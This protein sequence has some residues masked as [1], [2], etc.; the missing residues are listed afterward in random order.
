MLACN[1]CLTQKE[2]SAQKTGHSAT[3]MSIVLVSHSYSLKLRLHSCAYVTL[4]FGYGIKS[5]QFK[6]SVSTNARM[7]LSDHWVTFVLRMRYF[8]IDPFSDWNANASHTH[9]I[10]VVLNQV[11]GAISLATVWDCMGLLTHT[12]TQEKGT[13]ILARSE[14]KCTAY[15]VKET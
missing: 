2:S 8:S 9:T 5:V 3:F 15:A 12:D 14:R 7:R 13:H 11:Y 6:F 4:A 10:P 1:Y